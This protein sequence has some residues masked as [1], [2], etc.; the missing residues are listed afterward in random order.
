MIADYE[1]D[2]GERLLSP[3][4]YGLSQSHKH[5]PEMAA[6]TGFQT[7]P[8]SAPLFQATFPAWRS[9]YRF[10]KASFSRGFHPPT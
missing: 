6:V 4:Q 7:A 3:R 10:L 1:G 2:G 5:L 8:F 9:P